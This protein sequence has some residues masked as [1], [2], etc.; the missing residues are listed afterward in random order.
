MTPPLGGSGTLV[1]AIAFGLAAGALVGIQPSVNGHLGRH[2]VHPLQASL[3]SFASGT[4]I[5]MVMS[6]AGGIFPPRFTMS[7]FSMPWWVWAGGAMGVFMVTSSLILVP[8]IGSLP[9]FAAIMTGQVVAAVLLDHYGWLGNDRAVAS[10][11]RLAG[12]GL[13]IAG[14]GLIVYAKHSEHLSPSVSIETAA[15]TT[16]ANSADS[17]PKS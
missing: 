13:L 7:P 4:A 17:D 16:H 3:I 14:L 10:P 6:V 5:L 1:I 9:W 11:V 12:A 15:D 2:V 8:R